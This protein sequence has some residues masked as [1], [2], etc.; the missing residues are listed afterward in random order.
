MKPVI[1]IQLM[2]LFF[3]S[4]CKGPQI[5]RFS[6]T[7]QVIALQPLDTFPENVAQQLSTR[8]SDFFNKRVVVLHAMHIPLKPSG[9]IVGEYSADSII[10]MLSAEKNDTI[11]EV[12]GL[13]DFDLYTIRT[14]QRGSYYDEGIFGLGYEPGNA[15]VISDFKLKNKNEE[16]Y[17]RSIENAV[18]HEIGHNMGLPHCDNKKCVM[19]LSFASV[20]GLQHYIGDYCNKCRNKLNKK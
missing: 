8:L 7:D 12:V 9:K 15:C 20:Y 17:L 1:F 14:I 2:I 10:N 3:L 18:L 6:R 4:D 11:I 13:A 5:L 19:S 16:I